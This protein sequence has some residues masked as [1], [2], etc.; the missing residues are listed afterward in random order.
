MGSGEI[1]HSQMG[2]RPRNRG[3][4]S[5]YVTHMYKC[6][7]RNVNIMYYKHVQKRGTEKELRCYIHVLISQKECKH[8]VIH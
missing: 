5:G 7:T 2:R 6:H 4:E 3:K 8:Y 1:D